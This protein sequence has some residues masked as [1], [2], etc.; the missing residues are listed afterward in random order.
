VPPKERTEVTL[1]RASDLRAD[2]DQ[3]QVGVG[4][5]PLGPLD[6]APAHV[7]VGCQPGGVLEQVRKMGRAHLRHSGERGQG[8]RLIQ[9]GVDIRERALQLVWYEPTSHHVL[10]GLRGGIAAQEMAHE[11]L[12]QR[13]GV[14]LPRCALGVHGGL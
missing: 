12:G 11:R 7:L 6:A 3:G 9:M 14:Q 1:V 5:Q 10:S 13:L 8:Q 2:L 4:Q